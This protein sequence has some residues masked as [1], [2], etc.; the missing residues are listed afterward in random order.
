M[1]STS[2]SEQVKELGKKQLDFSLVSCLPRRIQELL[3]NP[4]TLE[5]PK[6]VEEVLQYTTSHSEI[7]KI[8]HNNPASDAM[9]RIVY[10][11]YNGH[12]LT[13]GLDYFLSRS[14]SGQALRDRL[15]FC[16]TWIAQRFIIENKKVIDLG[17]GSGSYAFES[18]RIK[19]SVPKNFYWDCL[20]LDEEAVRV[21]TEHAKIANLED[22][23]KFRQGNFMS[24]K[25]IGVLSDYAVL[26]GVL[27]GMDKPTAIN[28][29][30]RSKF[31]L[32]ESGEI[33]AATL[34]QRSFNEDPLTFRI[35]CN[36]G[37]WQLRP[38]TEEQIKQ[39]FFDAGYKIIK[40]YSER[41]N[42]AGQ[43]AIVHAKRS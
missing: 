37:G 36:I 33:L 38:K 4:L 27:C 15:N 1:A 9:L 40:I 26:I 20:D 19:G 12:S 14:L 13:G 3:G 31:H 6:K 43:Y 11:D 42:G 21:G 17:G 10:Q 18:F 24:E 16:S 22:T 28:C 29:L 35:L 5:D 39:I 7:A 8:L 34:L 2:L 32:K 30:E 41:F 23:L 25:S